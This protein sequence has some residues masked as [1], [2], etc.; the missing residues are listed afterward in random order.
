MPGERK[1]MRLH[2]SLSLSISFLLYLSFSLTLFCLLPNYMYV[3]FSLEYSFIALN[4]DLQSRQICVHIFSLILSHSLSLSLSPSIVILEELFFK[5]CGNLSIV[6][7]SPL[8]LSLSLPPSFSLVSLNVILYNIIHYLVL[9][10][11]FGYGRFC[12]TCDLLPDISFM[13]AVFHLE[14]AERL[15]KMSPRK[16]HLHE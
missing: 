15:C 8:S 4:T 1:C 12:E 2:F 13:L 7:V 3:Y 5:M 9:A 10:S 14:L 6:C 11:I 16:S